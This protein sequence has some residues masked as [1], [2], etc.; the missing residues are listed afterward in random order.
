ME[1]V[2]RKKKK[3]LVNFV[4]TSIKFFMARKTVFE[5]MKMYVQFNYL[6]TKN[7]YNVNWS[8]W[9]IVDQNLAKQM[10]SKNQKTKN[11]RIIRKNRIKK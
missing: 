4:D 11:G 8:I 2:Y 6:Q 3:C 1:K 10:M 5:H 7:D 9:K